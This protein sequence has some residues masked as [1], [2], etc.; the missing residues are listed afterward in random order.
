MKL[1]LAFV[2]PIALVA[3]DLNIDHAT[4]CGVNVDSMRKA[5]TSAANLPSEYGGP[6][7]NHATEMALVSF[8][9]GSYLELMG[10]QANPDPAAVASH[11]WSQ[12]LRNNAGPCAFA[13]RVTDIDREVAH[14]KSVRIPVG[15]PESS[16]RTRPDGTRLSWETV[17]EGS[18]PR[19]SLLPFLIRDITPRENRAF[20]SGKP[21]TTEYGGIGKV[22]VGVRDLE[23]AIALYRKA[24]G[25]TAPRREKD[26]GFDANLAWFEGTPIV[27]AQ[28]LSESSWLTRRVREYGDAPVAFVLKA[29]RGVIG[30]GHLS[31][32][33]GHPIFWADERQVGWRLG[34]E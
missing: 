19:G 30:A 7:S 2:L 15:R 28:G 32:W 17:D 9:D 16:G 10:I 22:V 34:V 24:F 20:P 26:T 5:L 29:T 14:L 13:L 25:L 21:T 31:T 8:P 12:F 18:G 1:L 4:V 23:G 11:V 27:L 6:H 3:A 33:F